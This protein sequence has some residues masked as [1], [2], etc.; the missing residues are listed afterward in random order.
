[1][2][3]RKTAITLGTASTRDVGTGAGNIPDMTAYPKGT[4]WFKLPTGHI[5]QYGTVTLTTRGV[6]DPGITEWAQTFNFPIAF[7]SSGTVFLGKMNS[8]VRGTQWSTVANVTKT[9]FIVFAGVKETIAA[10][11]STQ[12]TFYAVGK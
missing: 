11:V 3:T 1:M 4:G 5:I 10:G 6:S 12:V 7:P 2:A 9:S 8:N